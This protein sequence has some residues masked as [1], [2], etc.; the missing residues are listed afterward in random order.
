MHKA[1]LLLLLFAFFALACKKSKNTIQGT[2][3]RLSADSALQA[4]Y[5]DPHRTDT[6]CGVEISDAVG[7]FPPYPPEQ[8]TQAQFYVMFYDSMP[9]RF[10]G[11]IRGF[12]D[13]HTPNNYA[14]IDEVLYNSKLINGTIIVGG[15]SLTLRND[16]LIMHSVHG[17]CGGD[18]LDNFYGQKKK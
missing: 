5:Q 1:L 11:Q 16:S 17:G 2:G 3:N 8:T 6:F 12:Y 9:V 14:P 4:A 7:P 18:Y 15:I 13:G 10:I